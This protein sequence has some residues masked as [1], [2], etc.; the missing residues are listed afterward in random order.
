MA[1]PAK[2]KLGFKEQR[3]LD[4]LPALIESLETELARATEAMHSPEHFRQDAAAIQAA[5][6]AFAELQ[7][8][9]DQAYH[10]WNELE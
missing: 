7:A 3:E 8:R 2:R 5:G 10:R 4:A 9:L 6:R 1:A